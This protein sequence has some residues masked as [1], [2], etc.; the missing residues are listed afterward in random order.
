M[1]HSESTFYV[2]IHKEPKNGGPRAIGFAATLDEAKTA[3]VTKGIPKVIQT[4]TATQSEF[5][6][7][8]ARTVS[9]IDV[10][11]SLDSTVSFLG[12]S[13]LQIQSWVHFTRTYAGSVKCR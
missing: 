13:A 6:A 12:I 5:P 7:F 11:R 8:F 3:S 1:E 10:Y 4:K 9:A 2:V